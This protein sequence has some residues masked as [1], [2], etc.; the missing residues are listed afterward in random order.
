M[1]KIIFQILVFI[2][3]FN[4]LLNVSLG[5]YQSIIGNNQTSWNIKHQQL[6][7][8]YTDSLV[9]KNDTVI[10]G[11]NY[12][13]ILCYTYFSSIPTL[14]SYIGFLKEDT[15]TGKAWYFSTA[16]T[17]KQLITDMSLTEIDSFRISNIGGDLYFHVDSIYYISGKK[18]IRFDLELYYS[19]SNEKFTMIEG[20]GT[21]IGIRYSD[22]QWPGINPYL[23]CQ[24]KN[25]Q[26][27]YMND[28]SIFSGTCMI[29][30]TT[31]ILENNLKSKIKTYPNP[32]TN[33]ILIDTGDELFKN[34]RITI[35]NLQG[36]EMLNTQLYNNLEKNLFIDISNIPRGIY[37][38]NLSTE[39]E[40]YYIK[41]IK[42]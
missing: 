42:L 13:K 10:D 1:K 15:I 6:F 40:N 5:Q 7:G 16:D 38:I 18:H 20:T 9:V 29:I 24:Y 17:N 3:I 27:A 22:S 37:I 12:T 28:D 25:Y 21:N 26:L 2:S 41:L 30:T 19:T 36:K 14:Q 4:M 31:N 11:D 32:S 8:N 39:F 35:F 33:S 23:L 34:I